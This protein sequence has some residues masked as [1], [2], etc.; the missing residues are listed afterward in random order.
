MALVVLSG[1][2]LA[3]AVAV[4]GGLLGRS[5]GRGFWAAGT[6]ATPALAGVLVA[7]LLGGIAGAVL[8]AITFAV[9]H[10]VSPEPRARDKREPPKAVA[11]VPGTAGVTSTEANDR[12]APR[13]VGSARTEPS[14]AC[15]ECDAPTTW[16]RDHRRHY[17]TACRLYV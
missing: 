2:A 3:V 16:R 10:A 8:G 13:V 4:V 12:E 7:R 11:R 1:V 5:F 9:W 6:I 15:T 17:C 14:P